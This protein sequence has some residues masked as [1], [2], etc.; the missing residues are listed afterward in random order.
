L[1]RKL[2]E[3]GA[4]PS[5]FRLLAD[6]SALKAVQTTLDG[7]EY[8]VRTDLVGGCYRAFQAVGVRP[9][10]RIQSAGSGRPSGTRPI[11]PLDLTAA[12]LGE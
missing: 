7:N 12:S 2:A 9:P 3:L 1:Q 5:W 4:R 11:G 10:P 6:S 8:V